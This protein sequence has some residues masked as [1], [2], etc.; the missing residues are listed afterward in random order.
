MLRRV[1]LLISTVSPRASLLDEQSGVLEFSAKLVVLRDGAEVFLKAEDEEHLQVGPY[2]DL[3]GP[4]LDK[5]ER[6]SG[7]MGAL[8][9][10]GG[11][12]P[13]PQAGQAEVHP[14]I[15]QDLLSFRQ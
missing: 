6:H 10:L 4:F 12:Q 8:G 9:D 14:E 1:G 5:I 15:I 11:G 7:D 2:G 3:R 13:A